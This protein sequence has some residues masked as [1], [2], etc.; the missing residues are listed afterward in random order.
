MFRVTG[1]NGQY[2]AIKIKSIE[3]DLENLENLIE[4][5]DPVIIV[6]D[7]YDLENLGID[8]DEEVELITLDCDD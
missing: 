2:Y 5:S 4:G 3:D 8:P 6:A 1:R 7:I